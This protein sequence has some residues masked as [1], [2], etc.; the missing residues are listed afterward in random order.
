MKD[1]DE[2][3]YGE[4]I[5]EIYDQLYPEIEDSAID[6]L[7]E[8]AAGGPALELGVG[9]GRV[10]IPL[11]G[12]GVRVSGIDASPTMVAKL[13]A[14]PGG[15]TIRVF[16]T[17]FAEFSLGE[18]FSL[19]YVVFN[20]LYA[21]LTQEEQLG[22][23]VNV[24]NHLKPQGRFLVEAFV[25]DLC[26]YKRGQNLSVVDL[27]NDHLRLDASQLDP[28]AQQVTSQHILLSGKGIEL[29]PVKLRYTWPAEL[30]L[31]AQIAGLKLAHRWGDWDRRA[32]T[33]ESGRHISV[34]ARAA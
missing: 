25:P 4:R 11:Q 3:T 13:R 12:R 1:F 33:A 9:T 2:R 17:S 26:R 30:D 8:L 29:Y 23:L 20:T 16:E 6:L 24:A 5:A 34:Y 19:I 18:E 31:M 10:A 15:Q 22:C 32:F 28:V 7:Q 14:K 21:L 27:D